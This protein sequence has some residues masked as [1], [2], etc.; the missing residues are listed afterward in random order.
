M[1][2]ANATDQNNKCN[3]KYKCTVLYRRR[4]GFTT[5]VLVAATYNTSEWQW[6]TLQKPTP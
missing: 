4:N 3:I 2:N 1:E 6:H 5:D